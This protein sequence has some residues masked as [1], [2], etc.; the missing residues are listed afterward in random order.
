MAAEMSDVELAK[1]SK[2]EAP[3]KRPRVHRPFPILASPLTG[4]RP[5]FRSPD[6]RRG[7]HR[8]RAAQDPGAERLRGYRDD[9][10]RYHR[11]Q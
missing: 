9:R 8:V 1:S 6:G 3:S 4:S 2:G 10:P 7:R 11:R 5:L